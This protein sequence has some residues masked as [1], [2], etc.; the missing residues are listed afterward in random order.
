MYADKYARRSGFD[1][2]SAGMSIGLIAVI[3]AGLAYSS[4][5]FQRHFEPPLVADNI[6]IVPPPP[7]NNPKPTK[8]QHPTEAQPIDKAV[9]PD[10]IVKTET[11]PQPFIGA[12]PTFPTLPEG[13]GNVLVKQAPPIITEPLVDARY[14]GTFQPEY[15][16]AE[17]RDGRAGRVVVRVLIGVD[18]R[19]KQI[20]KVSAASDEFYKATER[21]ALEKWRFK[22]GTRDGVPIEAWRTM[23]VS[24]VINDED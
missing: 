12:T 19:V 7:P 9:V 21:R 14:A 18:G 3:T 11:P 23:S 20:E 8:P 13:G 24:F 10:P 4:P 16:A 5:V 22:P 17:R 15:P 1:P 2:G 6:P